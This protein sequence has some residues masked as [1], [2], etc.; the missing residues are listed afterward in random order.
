MMGNGG[1]GYGVVPAR[2]EMW[3]NGKRDSFEATIELECG[4][5]HSAWKSD[6]E[7]NI[8]YCKECAKENKKK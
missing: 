1:P 6:D 8:Y 7:Y 2:L 4:H 5:R 3:K